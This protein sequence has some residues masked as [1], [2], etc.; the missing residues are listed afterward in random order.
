MPFNNPISEELASF[1]TQLREH[2]VRYQALL[3]LTAWR[4]VLDMVA[5]CL[6]ILG[7]VGAV[8]WVGPWLVPLAILVIGNRQRAL[9]NI[10]HDA[11]HRNL[12]HSRVI[13]DS[14]ARLVLAPLGFVDLQHYRNVHF[15][16]HL[17]LGDKDSDPDY[18]PQRNVWPGGWVGAYLGHVTSA[19]AWWSSFAGH[20][21][22]GDVGLWHK[23]YIICWWSAVSA[24]VFALGGPQF[25]WLF[26]SLWLGA[27]A[28]LFH[29]IT[30]F[31]EMCD[32]FGLQAGGVASFTRDVPGHSLWRCLIHP[33][34][35]GYHLTH[36]LLP[37][38][39]YYKLPEAQRLFANMP[40][41]RSQAQ[42]CFQY[43]LGSSAAVV[44]WNPRK[45]TTWNE[46]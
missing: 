15:R 9:G 33:H 12:H 16:H 41:Y 6:A 27:R 36:H 25:F 31:R 29:A 23:G 5:D 37:T 30:T 22:S 24:L 17:Q 32:H 11:A 7:A 18:L 46:R 39:P 8:A 34:N 1:R 43:L 10:L 3:R 2:Q 35:N 4:P 44:A 20:L 40:L 42:V 14:I 45:D 28:T 21:G 13:N 38:V 26:V 19:K